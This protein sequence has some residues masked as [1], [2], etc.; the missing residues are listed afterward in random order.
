MNQKLPF[1]PFNIREAIK[2]LFSRAFIFYLLVSVF[3]YFFVD[4]DH[5]AQGMKTRTLNYYMPKSFS[6]LIDLDEGR[7]PVSSSELQYYISYFEKVAEYFPQRAD[8]YGFLGFCYYHLGQMAKAKEAY[9]TQARLFPKFFWAHYNLGIISMLQKN[10]AEA[11]ASFQQALNVDVRYTTSFLVSPRT[12]YGLIV[13]KNLR[14]SE[15]ELQIDLA[16]GYLNAYYALSG[17]LLKQDKKE[18]SDRAAARA[19]E[20]IKVLG[21]QPGDRVLIKIF[22]L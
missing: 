9:A 10:E 5:I 17:L 19:Q 6:Y 16:K 14:L 18:E 21:L 11:V 3:V 22:L 13:E 7:V 20:M 12:L 15:K 8:T 1:K 2:F 4:F